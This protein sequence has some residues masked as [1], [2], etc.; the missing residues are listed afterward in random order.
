VVSIVLGG[1][2]KLMPGFQAAYQVNFAPTVAFKLWIDR[3]DGQYRK[4]AFL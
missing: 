1:M 4:T 3:V 2:L